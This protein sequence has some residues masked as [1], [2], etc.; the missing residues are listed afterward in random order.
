[1]HENLPHSIKS[2]H[3]LF[4]ALVAGNT[5]A[6]RTKKTSYSPFNPVPAAL[7]AEMETDRPD[8][9]ES[10]HTV[11]AGH[12]QIESDLFRS[13]RKR[14][15]EESTATFFANNFYLKAGISGTTEL[16]MEARFST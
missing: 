11:D 4:V 3:L 9:S 5:S 12:L 14:V 1:M 15:E 8:L 7:M 6:Q 10:A 13:M 2:P 16:Q